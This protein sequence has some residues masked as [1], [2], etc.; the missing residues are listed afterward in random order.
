MEPRSVRTV[1]R[2]AEP[3]LLRP[4]GHGPAAG[5]RAGRRPG[6]RH[7]RA[8]RPAA[9]ARRR[10]RRAGRRLVAGHAGRRR[11]ARRRAAC[12]SSR[13]TSPRSTSPAPGTCCSPTPPCN[14][15]PTTLACWPAGPSACGPAAR[16]PCR[17]PPTP[18]TPRT[19]WP[20][21]SPPR[22]RS[23]AHSAARHPPM[24]SPPTCSPPE[25]YAELLHRLGFVEQ[26]VRL[27]VYGHQLATTAD[28]VEWVKG[29]SLTRFQRLMAPDLYDAVRAS[30]PRAARRPSWATSRRT[31]TRSSASCSGAGWPDRA[32]PAGQA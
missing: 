4:R 24:P 30:L 6:L 23:S 22:S 21:P 27:Q 26:H 9:G 28:V 16:W 2:R 31:S 5:G 32:R 17:C 14:G 11:G 20:Q 12:T 18:T 29:T 15:C 3:T 10:R 8:H 25:R 13:A 1:R 19:S 7:R